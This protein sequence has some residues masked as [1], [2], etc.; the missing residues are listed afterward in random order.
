MDTPLPPTH[1]SIRSKEL[2]GTRQKDTNQPTS[3]TISWQDHNDHL[4]QL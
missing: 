2:E 4:L 3:H 1:Q